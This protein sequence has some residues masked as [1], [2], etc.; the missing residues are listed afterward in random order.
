VLALDG[1]DLRGSV[2]DRRGDALLERLSA[3]R[4]G[5]NRLVSS[6]SLLLTRQ[7]RLT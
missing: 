7:L 5:H 4:F 6:L 3:G 1:E 2:E